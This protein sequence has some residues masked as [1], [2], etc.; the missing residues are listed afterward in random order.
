MVFKNRKREAALLTADFA[1]AGVKDAISLLSLSTVP[2][3]NIQYVIIKC[4]YLAI[5]VIKLTQI[6]THS[7][8][9]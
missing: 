4:S 6:H 1:Q 7:S 8:F 5:Y 2:G 3:N 9:S